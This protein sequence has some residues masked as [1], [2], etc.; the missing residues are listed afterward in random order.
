MKFDPVGFVFPKSNIPEGGA[1]YIES[2]TTEIVPETVIPVSYDEFGWAYYPYDMPFVRGG[3][4]STAYVYINGGKYWFSGSEDDVVNY[5][6]HQSGPF[7]PIDYSRNGR[8]DGETGGFYWTFEP[9]NDYY[10]PP[11]ESITISVE[12]T[13]H[14]VHTIDL[15]YLP[16]RL[17]KIDLLDYGID[18]FGMFFAGETQ[19]TFDR[20]E[21]LFALVNA[22]SYSDVNFVI[23]ASDGSL[24][25]TRAAKGG[26][27]FSGV[28]SLSSYMPLYNGTA[29][30]V[31]LFVNADGTVIL[32]AKEM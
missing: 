11:P 31:G 32:N 14:T 13:V 9:G 27:Y 19:A 2:K 29:Y 22:N 4:S 5:V 8:P 30:A 20:A 15:K 6:G 25:E 16:N 23:G 24:V 26:S 1:G 17:I 10:G 7:L 12:E 3:E 21:E 18:V 28:F